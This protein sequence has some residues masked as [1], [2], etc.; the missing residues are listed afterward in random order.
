MGTHISKRYSPV[1][2]RFQSNFM[3]NMVIRG[4]YTIGYL[5]PAKY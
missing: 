1:S 4:E 5:Q 2:T 3:K